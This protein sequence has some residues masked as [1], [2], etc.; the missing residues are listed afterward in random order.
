MT[1]LSTKFGSGSWMLP[2]LDCTISQAQRHRAS[3]AT[4]YIHISY[5]P[6][7]FEPEASNVEHCRTHEQGDSL[8]KNAGACGEILL[9][10]TSIPISAVPHANFNSSLSIAT[11]TSAVPHK[12]VEAGPNSGTDGRS[13]YCCCDISV[14]DD[15]EHLCLQMILIVTRCS[16]HWSAVRISESKASTV[17]IGPVCHPP[18]F[19]YV[20]GAQPSRR[21]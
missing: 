13:H 20:H 3:L 16:R 17:P 6:N 21:T 19:A 8:A 10:T 9:P 1:A 2:K 12:A 4:R 7:N 15:R 5:N 14:P 18:G 11:V